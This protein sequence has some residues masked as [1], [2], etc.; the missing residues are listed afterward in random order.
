MDRPISPELD[1]ILATV[2]EI[3]RAESHIRDLKARLAREAQAIGGIVDRKDRIAAAVYAYWFAPEV[4]AT[5]LS[6]AATGRRHA[7]AL[8]KYAGSMPTGI[9]CD[10]CQAELEI[11]SREQMKQVLSRSTGGPSYA[12]GYRLLCGEC[13]EL[14]FDAR[15][16]EHERA[17]QILHE[18]ASEIARMDYTD[19]L[20]TEDWAHQRVQYLELLLSQAK[21]PLECETCGTRDEFGVYHKTLEGMGWSDDLILLCEAC[22]DALLG[23]GRL[24]GR[25]TERNLVSK[26]LAGRLEAQHLDNSG[27]D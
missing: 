14:V 26:V 17:V 27:F 23:A 13:R 16:E 25:P 20:Q 12:E 1:T 5:D 15:L 3:R 22:A 9:A 10:R 4:H 8:L 7:S 24:A 2:E 6:F 11:T 19:Y 18:R 21:S